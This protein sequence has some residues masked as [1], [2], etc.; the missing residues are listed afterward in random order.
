MENEFLN[1]KDFAASAGVSVQ[2]VYQRLKKKKDILQDYVKEIDGKTMI[3]S[4]AIQEVYIEKKQNY[5]IKEPQEI[6]HLKE[7]IEEQKEQLKEKDSM[8]NNLT[9][10]LKTKDDL[11]NSL[12]EQIKTQTN[13]LNQEQQ[14]NLLNQQ[15]ILM[16]EERTDRKGILSIFKK[17][18]K[19]VKQ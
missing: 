5:T 4:V 16:L 9:E 18:N 7:R 6:E 19:E 13:L 15:K 17:K 11:I 14:L 3:S 10:Q 2:S 1:I 12:M 8:I